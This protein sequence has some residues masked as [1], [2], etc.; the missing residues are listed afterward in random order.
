LFGILL[1]TY[2]LREM[3]IAFKASSADFNT[4]A[5]KQGRPL[6]I[7]VMSLP[8]DGVVMRAQKRAFAAHARCFIASG[9]YFCHGGFITDFYYPRNSDIKEGWTSL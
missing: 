6:E 3:F 1:S 7:W 9:T 4:L 8:L 5:S 2:C